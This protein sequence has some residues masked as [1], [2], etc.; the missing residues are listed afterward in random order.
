MVLLLAGITVSSFMLALTSGILT[1]MVQNSLREYI[2][3]M[4]GGLDYR[5]WEHV[6][7]ASGPN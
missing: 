1:V 2:F 6:Y 3:W 7:L 4:V 5:R